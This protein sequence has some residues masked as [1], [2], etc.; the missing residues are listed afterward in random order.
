[1]SGEMDEAQLLAAAEKGKPQELATQRAMPT[2]I[3]G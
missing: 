3:S 2:I 1:M